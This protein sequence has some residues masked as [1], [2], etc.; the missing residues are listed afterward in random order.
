MSDHFGAR[1]WKRENRSACPPI[2]VLRVVAAT[3]AVN[4]REIWEL[5]NVTVGWHIQPF[6]GVHMMTNNRTKL[7]HTQ[8]GVPT[9][10]T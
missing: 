7:K 4:I 9:L 5:L 8:K 6:P 10:V 2:L 1:A 3:N